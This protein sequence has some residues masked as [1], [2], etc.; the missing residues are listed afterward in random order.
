[1]D[2]S[3]GYEEYAF[4]AEFYDHVVPYRER[5]DV[6]FFRFEVEHLLARSGFRVEEVYA[7]YDWSPYGS[8]EPG[9][10]I[11]MALKA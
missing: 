7:D 2:R 5:Q 4:V 9:E 8:K 11:V 10:L 3:G 1:M 6:A